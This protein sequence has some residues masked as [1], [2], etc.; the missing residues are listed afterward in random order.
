MEFTTIPKGHALTSGFMLGCKRGVRIESLPWGIEVSEQKSSVQSVFPELE[1]LRM[2]QER[3]ERDVVHHSTSQKLHDL[4]GR[5]V[6]RVVQEQPAQFEQ[7]IH[8]EE[9]REIVLLVRTAFRAWANRE[10]LALLR[11]LEHLAESWQVEIPEASSPAY[12]T[13]FAA[14]AQ[15]QALMVQLG[16]WEELDQEHLVEELE[17][18]SRSEHSQLESRLDVLITHLLKW[19]FDSA[20]Q[21]PRRLWRATI[22]E[23]RHRLTRLLDRSSSLRPTLPDALQQSYPHARLMAIDETGLPDSILPATC[24]WTVQQILA[25]DFLPEAMP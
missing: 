25:D 20:S 1:V 11:R 8:A 9:L 6:M 7:L 17:A 19:R 18:L 23:Q 16:M 2:L 21:D 12:E 13:D 10:A 4:L 3:L 24:P 14:W 15:H 5:L 22:R